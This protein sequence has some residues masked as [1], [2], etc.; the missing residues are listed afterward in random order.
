MITKKHKDI[1]RW[2]DISLCVLVLMVFIGGITRLTQSGLSMT[3]WKP[4]TG[5]IPPTSLLQ[6]QYE[7]DEYKKYPEFKNSNMKMTLTD[8]KKIYYWEYIHRLLGRLI[9][10]LFLIPF[11]YFFIKQKINK[12]LIKKLL[13]LFLMGGFQGFLGWYMVQSGLTSNPYISHYRLAIHLFF[14]FIIIGYIYWIRLSLVTIKEDKI[15]NHKYFNRFINLI[16]VIFFIQLVYGAFMA[17][18]KA[19]K[20][21]NTFPLIDGKLIPYNLFEL[22]PLYVNFF[23]NSKMVQFIHR[24]LGLSLMIF[25]Y[26]ISFNLKELNLSLNLK[27]RNLVTI[28]TFQVFLGIITLISKVSIILALSHQFLAILLYLSLLNLKHSMRWKK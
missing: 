10:V 7:F 28:V 20:F 4:I 5:I 1:V 27:C 24:Y 18:L 2:L 23:E 8:Y 11:T 3:E 25:I 22:K 15:I 12:I 9:G 21:W 26:L 14:T 19:G 16:L 13:F 17:G 6:W